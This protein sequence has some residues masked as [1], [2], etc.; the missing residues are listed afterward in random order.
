M[1]SSTVCDAVADD[2]EDWVLDL[3]VE[4]M[5]VE[6]DRVLSLVLVDPFGGV[7]PDWAPGAH[8]DVVLGG[9]RRQYSLCGDPAD[10]LSYRIAVLREELSRGGS[11]YAHDV[12]R[13]G[14]VLEVGGPRNHFELEEH[15][16][17]R[18]LAGGIGVTPL[19]PMIAA[20]ARRGAP[21]R[22]A[23]GGRTSASMA[24]LREL[25]QYGAQVRVLPEDRYGPLDLDAILA[26]PRPGV[27]IYACGPEGL[28]KAVERRCERWPPDALHLERFAATPRP[29][30]P[31]A[32]FVAVCRRGGRQVAVPAGVTLLD[33][34][35]AAGVRLASACREGVCG[36]CA[37]GV[38]DG[39]VD[40]RDSVLSAR[41]RDAG[42]LMMACTSR[43]SGARLVLDI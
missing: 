34:L 33:A 7:L 30:A 28:L 17:Y 1:S 10:R 3:R 8:I 19:L 32:D 18:F 35:E 16:E 29:A 11:A 20:V 36:S 21:W 42:N 24:F 40:H 23:Y 4:Q 5:R 22:L 38:L 2:V 39:A 26:D 37:I 41:E 9:V 27:G 43:A 14:D 12:L 31:D 6:A 15:A 25:G 13:P